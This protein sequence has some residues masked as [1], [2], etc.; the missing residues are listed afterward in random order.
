MNGWDL[1][2]FLGIVVNVILMRI[3]TDLTIADT[4]FWV[5]MLVPFLSRISGLGSEI[6]ERNKE[7]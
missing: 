3:Y 1:V 7:D 6:Q 2:Y 5:W 4:M